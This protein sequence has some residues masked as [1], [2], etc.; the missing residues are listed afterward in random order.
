LAR[1]LAEQI[2]LR[3]DAEA[4]NQAKSTFLA[5]MSHELRSPL[6]AIIGFAE[7]LEKRIVNPSDPE[8]VVEYQ[9]YILE[10]GRH[11]LDLINDIL[12]L[13]RIQSSTG[14]LSL[15]RVCVRDVVDE[16]VRMVQVFA[17]RKEVKIAC[18]LADPEMQLLTDRRALLQI[19]LNLAS[20]AVKFSPAGG[21]VAIDVSQDAEG[22]SSILVC[23]DGRGME[24]KLIA[25]VG[26][27]FLRGSDSF[28]ANNEGIGLG[29]AITVQLASLLG[30]TL[31]FRNRQ[32]HGLA[33]RATF[34]RHAIANSN[35]PIA[36][37]PNRPNFGAE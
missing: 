35:A 31:A 30:G 6:N 9:G 7:L 3:A 27:P 14:A 8:K 34:P 25:G 10:S 5:A 37:L 12:H 26:T 32:P 13:A 36:L 15:E 4:A 23:D 19:V 29:L 16:A 22:T 18:R 21:T 24:P 17:E 11:L 2:K 33:A 1:G 20:N 28:V